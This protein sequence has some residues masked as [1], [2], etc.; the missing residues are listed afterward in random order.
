MQIVLVLV[1]LGAI[2]GVT[3]MGM[4]LASFIT[5]FVLTRHQRTKP[6]ALVFLL[7]VPGAWALG[8]TLKM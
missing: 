2:V 8:S 1:F 6:L 5:G 7:I 4:M 3:L